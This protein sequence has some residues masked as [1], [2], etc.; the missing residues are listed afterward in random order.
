[1]SFLLAQVL[2]RSDAK[3]NAFEAPAGVAEIELIFPR[4]LLLPRGAVIVEIRTP[5]E[6]LVWS[7]PPTRSGVP[8]GR[9]A[10]AAA[11]VV[12]ARQ[13]ASGDY[14]V[15]VIEAAAP[16]VPLGRY[17]MRSTRH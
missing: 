14:L 17:S 8:S 12:P 11:I 6:V 1:V 7:G 5:D 3:A 10:F 9:D 4:D 16:A 15:S 13:L 2:T